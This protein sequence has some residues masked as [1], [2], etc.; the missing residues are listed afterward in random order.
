MKTNK[1]FFKSVSA[2]FVIFLFTVSLELS[3]AAPCT[4]SMA[5]KN[6]GK[7]GYMARS[8][9]NEGLYKA[10][11]KEVL[12]RLGCELVI[13]RYPKKRVHRLLQSG[14]IDIYPSTGFNEQR[15]TYLFYES[16]GLYRY[17]PYLG[18]TP[19]FVEHL[20]S[21]SD[22]GQ[23][24]LNWIFEAGSTTVE[25]ATR[26]QVPYQEIVGLTYP[27]AIDMLGHG[28]HVFYRI[29]EA[30][31]K[32]YLAKNKVSDLSHLMIR[33][34]KTCCEP[35]SQ[36]LYVGISR[37][38]VMVEEEPNPF[39]DSQKPIS[40]ENFPTKLVAGTLAYKLSK[41]LRKMEKNGEI[42]RLYHQ[43]ILNR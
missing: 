8:P 2:C 25:E 6:I 15:S 32:R 28:R 20:E 12:G 18:L 22:I 29:I 30:D 33:T 31:Y 39:Y 23:L 4:I 21:I 40:A 38:S 14:D 17:E 7:P 42:A 9:S 26:M 36:K 24:G 13:K 1:S 34:H 3:A 41:E 19:D 43:Y 10:L 37:H 11:Y 5:Y 27:R 35:K 16:N